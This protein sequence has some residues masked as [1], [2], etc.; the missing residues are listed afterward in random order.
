MILRLLYRSLFSTI[1]EGVRSFVELDTTMAHLHVTLMGIKNVNINE[2]MNS[3]RKVSEQTGTK[4][5]DV[6]KA[7]D[8]FINA[9]F[10]VKTSLDGVTKASQLSVATMGDIGK[11]AET[12]SGMFAILKDNVND[13]TLTQP[14]K[15]FFDT[16][17][18][19]AS[20]Q[21]NTNCGSNLTYLISPLNFV[22]HLTPSLLGKELELSIIL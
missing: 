21:E 10:D 15:E 12:V 11:S 16:I 8:I 9:G 5:L 3:L 13:A 7:F 20:T 17:E 6:S 1:A 2:V 18:K 14:I 19:G 4:I 22:C